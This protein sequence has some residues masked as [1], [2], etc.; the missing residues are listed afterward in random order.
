M[1]LDAYL[2]S[3]AKACRRLAGGTPG[4]VRGNRVEL[5]DDPRP[6]DQ[7][8]CADRLGGTVA[9]AIKVAVAES[10]AGAFE[11]LA[12]RTERYGD[13]VESFNEDANKIV[14]AMLGLVPA[15]SGV[16]VPRSR[17]IGA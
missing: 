4:L 16:R 6:G 17:G 5:V 1:I 3:F 7:W 12:H 10:H 9:R 8:L 11:A 2:N 13:R 14:A 15:G